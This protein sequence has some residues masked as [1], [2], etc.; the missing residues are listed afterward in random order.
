MSRRVLLIARRELAAA[1]DSAIAPV[2]LIVS[3]LFVGTAFMNSFFLVGRV[4]MTSLFTRLPLFLAVFV[5]A[6]TMRL[7]A[8][9]RK[10]RTIELLFSLPLTTT[11]AV[12][13]KFVASLALIA[14]FLVGTLPI[15]AML[16]WL[17]NPDGGAIAAGYLG[18]LLLGAELAA[19][20]LFFSA[21]TGDQIV[22]FIAAAVSGAALVLAGDPRVKSALDGLADDPHAAPGTRL[23]E[24]LSPT[25]HFEEFTRGVV[26]LGGVGFFVIF[27][28]ALLWAAGYVL[29]RERA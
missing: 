12:L 24:L 27:A 8:E 10:T 7:F 19:L 23:A 13:G 14:I 4:E 16:A 9:E 25:P 20:G 15:P 3:V 6:L 29:R 2:A 17:G 1:F 21:L 11:E 28:A 18:L 22:A 5:P 26:S